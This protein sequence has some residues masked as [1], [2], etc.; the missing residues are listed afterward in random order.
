MSLPKQF[1]NLSNSIK[2]VLYKKY[3]KSS[4]DKFLLV[5][6]QCSSES[7]ELNYC[8]SL[9]FFDYTGVIQMIDFIDY[10]AVTRS[11]RV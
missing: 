3:L 1:K 4:G 7:F 11:R 2:I 10:F 9:E 6:A 8:I 5:M